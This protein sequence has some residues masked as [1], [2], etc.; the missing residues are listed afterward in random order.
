MLLHQN[1]LKIL[2]NINLKQKNKINSNFLKPFSKSKNKQPNNPNWFNRF[3]CKT[4][5]SS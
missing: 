4:G 3:M 1:N 5:E 2:K